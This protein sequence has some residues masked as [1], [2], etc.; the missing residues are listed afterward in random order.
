MS[1]IF[2]RLASRFLVL[3][4]VQ[5]PKP[6]IPITGGEIIQDRVAR[7]NGKIV[8]I[9]IHGDNFPERKDVNPNDNKQGGRVM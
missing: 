3:G 5:S 4:C 8:Q 7:E 2:G 6:L 1:P 9:W